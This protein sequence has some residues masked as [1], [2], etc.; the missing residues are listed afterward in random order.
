MCVYFF[1][2]IVMDKNFKDIDLKIYCVNV[3]RVFMEKR[4]KCLI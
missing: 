2:I 1:K 3:S 4:K